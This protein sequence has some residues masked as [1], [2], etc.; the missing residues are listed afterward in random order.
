MMRYHLHSFI[1]DLVVYV[2]EGHSK[3]GILLLTDYE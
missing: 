1:L 3:N 2:D